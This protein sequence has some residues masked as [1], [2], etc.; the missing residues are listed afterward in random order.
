MFATDRDLLVLEP[1]L[2]RDAAWL[3]QRL[4]AATGSSTAS[5]LTITGGDFIGAGVTAGNVLLLDGLPVEVVSVSGA[6]TA[7]VSL[8]RPDPDDPPIAPQSVTSRPVVVFTF[9]PQIVLIHNQVLRMLGIEPADP[10]AP[11]FFGRPT[12]ASITNPAALALVEALGALH[13]VYS[14]AAALSDPD[15]PL[16]TRAEVYRQR[17]SAQRHR[18]AAR[19]DLDGDGLPDATRRLNIV[20]FTRA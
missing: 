1:N 6:A 11:P 4:L 16:A 3:G 13:L 20:Q 7:I 5:S 17:F 18:T 15:S 12:A 2:F 14:A 19:I 10:P 8:L 9:R